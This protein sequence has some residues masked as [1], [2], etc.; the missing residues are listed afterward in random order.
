MRTHATAKSRGSRTSR[1]VE[2]R[3]HPIL[4]AAATR[5]VTGL[6]GLTGSLFAS[7][8]YIL[9]GQ[10]S[11]PQ[12]I[13]VFDFV[14]RYPVPS[15]LV[16]AGLLL[17]TIAALLLVH[18]QPNVA[19]MPGSSRSRQYSPLPS[20]K[21]WYLPLLAATTGTAT[22]STLAVV[23]IL[24]LVLTHPS[25]CPTPLCPQPPGPHDEYLE[26]E[27]TAIQSSTYVLSNDPSQYSLAHLPQT[28]SPSVV[29]AQR[30]TPRGVAVSDEPYR[31]VVRVHELQH[32]G[33]GM[34]IE[35]VSVA[36]QDVKP[37]PKP[38]RV[39]DKGAP[40]DYRS[41]PYQVV[42]TA[43]A[44][45]T[46]LQA[47]YLGP[48]RDAHVQLAPGEVDELGIALL[49]DTEARLTFQIEI[50]YRLNSETH[51]RTLK[52]P[53]NFAVVFGDA[54]NLQKYRLTD[55]SLVPD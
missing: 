27:L 55:G 54:A 43:S 13:P 7:A 31:I 47:E 15:F 26:A 10:Q 9:V 37:V 52:L 3:H 41:N 39:W 42:Y 19:A 18:A 29:A 5:W 24:G 23:G 38:L 12:T 28:G 32:E 20:R 30:T 34:F 40:L 46:R 53:Y 2:S 14:R 25:W 21:S 36:V 51:L 11:P 6:T 1:S 45:G 49:S 35:G 44:R 17:L 4:Y 50:E 8:V 48:L 22:V 33:P 16:V